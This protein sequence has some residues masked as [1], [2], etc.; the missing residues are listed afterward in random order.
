MELTWIILLAL[1]V[2]GA[3]WFA[4]RRITFSTAW[5]PTF[6]GFKWWYILAAPFLFWLAFFTPAGWGVAVATDATATAVGCGLQELADATSEE[7]EDRTIQQASDLRQAQI[8]QARHEAE[9]ARAASLARAPREIPLSQVTMGC[10]QLRNVQSG[11]YNF[12]VGQ[13]NALNC[14]EVEVGPNQYYDIVLDPSRSTPHCSAAYPDRSGLVYADRPGPD[15]ISN[16]GDAF[17]TVVVY[18]TPLGEDDP[19]GV[20]C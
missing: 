14:R 10:E 5:I 17:F 16:T 1:I 15:R 9:V 4:L 6:S 8:E 2:I 7:C 12:V 13:P 3:L 20:E 19:F 18:E 11:L